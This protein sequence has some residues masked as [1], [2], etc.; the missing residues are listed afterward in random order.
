MR[1]SLITVAVAPLLMVAVASCSSGD[2]TG[3][4]S[5]A[6]VAAPSNIKDIET[7]DQFCAKAEEL[8]LEAE[9][10]E[11]ATPAP[12]QEA[13]MATLKER[14]DLAAQQQEI[15]LALLKSPSP[16]N[17]EVQ[18]LTDCMALVPYDGPALASA[19]PAAGSTSSRPTQDLTYS[20]GSARVTKTATQ[21]A[22][23]PPVEQV[24]EFT[25]PLD[26]AGTNTFRTS[27]GFN[28][29]WRTGKQ[30]LNVWGDSESGRV[31]ASVRIDLGPGDENAYSSVGLPCQVVLTQYDDAGIAGSF[32]CVS[33]DNLVTP[34]STKAIRANGTFTASP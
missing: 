11:S 15:L 32:T 16:D 28:I 29:F 4:T 24:E 27:D 23:K 14:S 3:A 31:S 6:P 5:T 19:S 26:P 9:Q 1:K 7:V 21:V 13:Q 18:K 34:K 8:K 20:T 17:A 10:A 33:M 25:A 30:A 22:G 12:D 2:S